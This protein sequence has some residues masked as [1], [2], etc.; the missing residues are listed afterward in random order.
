MIDAA[1]LAFAFTAG[2]LALFSPCALPLLPGY[3][4]YYLGSKAPLA[5]ALQGGALCALGAISTFLAMGA[6][7]SLLGSL[8]SKYVPALGAVAGAVLAFMGVTMLLEIKTLSFPV[9]VEAP[10][11]G[12]LKGLFVYGAAYGLASA[13]CAAPIFFSVV[14][15]ALASGGLLEGFLAFLAYAL[16]MAIPLVF[17][18]MLVAK[19]KGLVVKRAIKLIPLLQK[20][21]GGLLVAAGAYLFYASFV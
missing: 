14:V 4:S 8:A 1:G 3:I 19:A 10:K 2:V 13:G 16:G 5:K 17:V 11:E 6:I 15:Y 21:A 20:I 18:T 9:P 12:G 7:V